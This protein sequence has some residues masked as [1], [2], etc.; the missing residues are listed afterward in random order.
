MGCTGITVNAIAP[1]FFAT[2]ANARVVAQKPVADWLRHRTALGRWGEPK[3][4][5]GAA[6]FLAS[7]ASTYITGQVIAVDG[8]Y[9]SHF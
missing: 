3:E 1:G 4:I 8:G 5:A 7:P 2:E 6:V 9:L